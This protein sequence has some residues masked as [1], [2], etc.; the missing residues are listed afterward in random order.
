[1]TLT[2]FR[3]MRDS[4]YEDKI[5][6][7]VVEETKVQDKTKPIGYVKLDLA[8]FADDS[9]LPQHHDS[10]KLTLTPLSKKLVHGEISISISTQFI[11]E[12]LA[13][14]E[15][16][17]SVASLLSMQAAT[18]DIGNLKDFDEANEGN[19][20]ASSN[21]TTAII[22][23]E[24]SQLI[25]E[26]SDFTTQ[27]TESDDGSARVAQSHC[28]DEQR[29]TSSTVE[30]T[31]SQERKV[32]E[33]D[34]CSTDSSIPTKDVNLHHD[35]V[36]AIVNSQRDHIDLSHPQDKVDDRKTANARIS[37]KDSN[38]STDETVNDNSS[39]CNKVNKADVQTKIRT[40][41]GEAPSSSSSSFP[42]NCKEAAIPEEAR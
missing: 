2:L 6:H 35:E 14:D 11:K 32:K 41:D 27:S 9:A 18:E 37:E 5:Y 1:M 28:T 42:V 34:N 40:M 4:K 20:T 26:I 16:M 39:K 29:V 10:I 8:Q 33:S 30:C 24:L 13:S 25:N 23:A 22:S 21:Q 17:I 12:G 15:D 7:L 19:T 31:L 38:C 3:G 36:T